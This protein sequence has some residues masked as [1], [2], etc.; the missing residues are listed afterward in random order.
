MLIQHFIF[1]HYS[2]NGSFCSTAV[3]T[4][5]GRA[6]YETFFGAGISEGRKSSSPTDKHPTSQ[7]LGQS[8]IPRIEALRSFSQLTASYVLLKSVTSSIK[9][10]PASKCKPQQFFQNSRGYKT[11]TLPL[12][13]VSK[14]TLRGDGFGEKL[15]LIQQPGE[16]QEERKEK[17]DE[18]KK[19]GRGRATECGFLL[20]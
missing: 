16:R 6:K 1:V 5:V 14:L 4:D 15:A 12:S 7:H 10:S 20:W 2:A 11:V 17:D 18:V 9:L 8:S 3:I 13:S 19:N